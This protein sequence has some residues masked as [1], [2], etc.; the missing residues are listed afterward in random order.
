MEKVSLLKSKERSN[1]IY[2]QSPQANKGLL[3]K[4]V[5]LNLN[6]EDKEINR[7]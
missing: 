7:D 1:R 6:K 2:N 3:V 4:K 5:A